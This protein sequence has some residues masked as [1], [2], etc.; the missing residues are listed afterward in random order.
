MSTSLPSIVIYTD[1]IGLFKSEEGWHRN[2]KNFNRFPTK[3]TNT[4]PMRTFIH[5]HGADNVEKIRAIQMK[6]TN[7]HWEL[8][9]NYKIVR[10]TL[11]RLCLLILFYVRIILKAKINYNRFA[12]LYVDFKLYLKW[13]WCSQCS[14]SIKRNR[15]N[16]HFKSRKKN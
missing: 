7:P 16:R 3:D 10:E 13:M 1:R 6:T 11:D 8:E 5:F 15:C 12:A 2:A 14:H 9:N 4:H